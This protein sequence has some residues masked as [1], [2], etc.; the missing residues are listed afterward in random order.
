MKQVFAILLA[1]GVLLTGCAAPG[2]SGS[3]GISGT[4]STGP[5]QTAEVHT[6]TAQEAHE[7][8]ESGDPMAIVDVRTAAEYAESHIPGAIL[9]PNED[10]G[11]TAPAQLP[12]PDAEIL[13]YCRS[14]NRSAQAA[15]KLVKLGYTNVSDFGGI[16]DWPYETETGAWQEK[17]GTLASFRATTLEGEPVDESLFAD[18]KLTMINIWATFCGPCLQEMPE[19]GKLSE[20]YQSRGVQLVGIVA[21]A[22]VPGDDSFLSQ[23]ELARKLVE[24]TG[25]KYTHLLP[26]DDLIQAKLGTVSAVPETVFVDSKG[27]PVGQSYVGSRSGADWA[28]IID[29]LLAKMGA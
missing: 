25:A 19:L 18:Y 22:G 8:I 12:V 3:S 28:K 4:G 26:S 11:D 5:V 16:I 21:D 27:N 15:K 7:R 20:S 10:I 23:V 6:I 14:G 2:A 17:K 29:G 1:A 24:Q 13:V 9:L